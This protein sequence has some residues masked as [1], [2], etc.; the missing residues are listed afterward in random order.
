MKRDKN[1]WSKFTPQEKSVIVYYERHSQENWGHGGYYPDDMR[2]CA[3][4]GNPSM[5][6]TCQ[7]CDKQYYDILKVTP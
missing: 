2:A 3:I 4:C 7:E 6:T 1:W 5:G